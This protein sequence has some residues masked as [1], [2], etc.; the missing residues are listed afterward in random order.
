MGLK[1]KKISY[2]QLENRLIKTQR[3]NILLL[4]SDRNRNGEF[5]SVLFDKNI[6]IIFY[7]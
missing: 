5:P 1:N 2:L 7:W 3:D 6:H 4:I